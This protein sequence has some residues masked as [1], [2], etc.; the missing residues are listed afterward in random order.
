MDKHKE[1][2]IVYEKHANELFRFCYFR[3]S[4]KET[5][6]DIVADAFVKFLQVEMDS[7]REPRAWLYRVCRNLIYDLRVKESTEK[8]LFPLNLNQLI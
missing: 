5:A 4:N 1:F 7:I 8:D 2:E 6:Q 3:L